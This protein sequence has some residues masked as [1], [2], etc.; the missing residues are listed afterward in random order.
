MKR[1]RQHQHAVFHFGVDVFVIDAIG[2]DHAARERTLLVFALYPQHAVFERRLD[3]VRPET[4][5]GNLDVIT[6][7]GAKG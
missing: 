2:N 1:Q 6:R 4:G 7:L 3:L 5:N